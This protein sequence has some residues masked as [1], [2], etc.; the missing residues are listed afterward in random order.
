M[1]KEKQ[2]KDLSWDELL[3][4]TSNKQQS[5]ETLREAQKVGKVLGGK[6]A[7]AKMRDEK[8]GI[9]NSKITD[10]TKSEWSKKGGTNAISKVN[11]INRK[12]GH[13]DKWSKINGRKAFDKTAVSFYQCDMDDNIIKEWK[14]IKECA[15]ELGL[16]Y[17]HISAVLQGRR[18][19]HKGYKWKYK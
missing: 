18:K 17:Q 7:G 12:N 15:R 6:V 16:T 19:S 3:E 5:I 8:K 4:A 10:K 9:F 11:E 2:L 13:W 14:G 1:S